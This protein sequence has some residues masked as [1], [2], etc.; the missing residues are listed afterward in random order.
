MTFF[1]KIMVI[2]L[3][4]FIKN[5]KKINLKKVLKIFIIMAINL[6]IFAHVFNKKFFN[7]YSKRLLQ[8]LQNLEQSWTIISYLR[9][10]IY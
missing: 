10:C 8:C 1:Y 7:N 5:F 3:N 2:N 6:N 4:I 9:V